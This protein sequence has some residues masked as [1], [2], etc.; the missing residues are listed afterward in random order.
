MD[1]MQYGPQLSTPGQ[2]SR[3]ALGHYAGLSP[4]HLQALP[5]HSAL[6]C[7]GQKDQPVQVKSQWSA[8]HLAG[9]IVLLLLWRLTQ[10]SE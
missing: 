10:W 6:T 1:H 7:V 4:C 9:G 2:V 3:Q 5:K 8:L